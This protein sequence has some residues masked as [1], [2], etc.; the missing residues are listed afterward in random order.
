MN[1]LQSLETCVLVNNNLSGKLASSLEL[2]IIFDKRFS[3]TSE[4]FFIP[5]FDLVVN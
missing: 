4:T 5:D 1:Y 3:V 2:T